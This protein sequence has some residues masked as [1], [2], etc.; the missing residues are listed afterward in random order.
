LN[1]GSRPPDF[2]R[3]GVDHDIDLPADQ[4]A[5]NRIRVAP[6]LNRA[7]AVDLDPAHVAPMIELA[8]RQLAQAR[9]LPL[10]LV[11]AGRVPLVDQPAE[12]LFVLGAAGKIPLPV[13]MKS[14]VDRRFQMTVRRFDV[15]ILMRLAGV[16]PLGL[17]LIVVHQVAVSPPKLAVFRKV[18]DRRAE[19]VATVPGWHAAQFPKGLLESAADR[20]E[21]FG[22][23]DRHELPIRVGEGEVIQQVVE[24]LAIDGDSQRV[25]VGE[26]RRPQPAGLMHLGKHD[27]LM[28]AVQT[29]PVADA[30]LEGPPLRVGKPTRMAL[31]EPGEKSER[32]Q[33]GF[34]FQ[35]SLDLGPDLAERVRPGSPTAWRSAL[36][37]QAIPIAILT[38]RLLIHSS[39]PCRHGEAHVARQKPPQLSRLS[40]RDHRNLHENQELRFWSK[41]PSIGNS[42]CRPAARRRPRPPEK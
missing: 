10:E 5:G 22:K 42:N 26:V 17:D 36:G 40:I 1:P 12:E 27:R 37:G 28:G 24:R 31:L 11:G 41:D 16:G 14:L 7:A 23:A 18:V 35:T 13:Q 6:D 15:P 33:P 4:S 21:R 32:P 25:H 29:T 20:L 39:P 19:A 30:T 3:V 34:G 2:N 8:R 38:S 9:L